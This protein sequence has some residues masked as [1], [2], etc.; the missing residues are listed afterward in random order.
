MNKI[1]VDDLTRRKAFG[2]CMYEEV[3]IAVLPAACLLGQAAYGR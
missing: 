2:G 1:P 3:W